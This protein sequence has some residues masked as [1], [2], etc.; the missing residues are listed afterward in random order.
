MGSSYCAAVLGG[1]QHLSGRRRA[2]HGRTT[3]PRKESGDTPP[4]ER[5]ELQP[6]VMLTDIEAI[7]TVKLASNPCTPYIIPV[8]GV[9]KLAHVEAFWD[10]N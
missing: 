9:L 10:Q 1:R 3:P 8:K 2:S 4:N 6:K 5:K 7:V